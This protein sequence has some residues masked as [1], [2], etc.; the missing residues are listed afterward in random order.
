MAMSRRDFVAALISAGAVS[1]V[2]VAAE[3]KKE[4]TPVYV[5]ATVKVK[6]GKRDELVRIFKGIVPEVHAEE[7][8]IYYAPAVDIVSGITAQEP[9][10]PNVMVVVEKWASLT[11][12]IAHL[13]APHMHSYRAA[14]K[15]L[16]EGVSLQVLQP[17]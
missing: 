3:E 14:V 5:V 16:V 2:S 13:D 9:I 7:G 8:C 12:L 15:D 10:R 4:D 17:A 11:N 6:E 1:G